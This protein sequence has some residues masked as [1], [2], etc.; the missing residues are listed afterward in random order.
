MVVIYWKV[1]FF[2]TCP[3]FLLFLKMNA[4]LFRA[5]RSAQGI[6]GNYNNGYFQRNFFCHQYSAMPAC[7]P[8]QSDKALC[9]LLTGQLPSS[10]LDIPRIDSR[11]VQKMVGLRH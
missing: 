1:H 3:F 7:T 5:G 2:N 4:D 8:V 9:I 10:H 11:Q 6:P